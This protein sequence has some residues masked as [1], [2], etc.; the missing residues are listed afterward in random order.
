MSPA[1][2]NE[3]CHEVRRTTSKRSN[4]SAISVVLLFIL[5]GTIALSCEQNSQKSVDEKRSKWVYTVVNVRSGRSTDYPIVSQLQPG[6]KA[7]VD[8][9]DEGWYR[10]FHGEKFVGYVAEFLLKNERLWLPAPGNIWTGV[11]IYYGEDL[12]KKYIGQ[13]FGGRDRLLYIVN[14]NGDLEVYNRNYLN[15]FYYH[16]RSDDPALKKMKWRELP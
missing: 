1:D 5:I 11:N 14:E 10:V 6:E 16:V 7:K 3:C 12:N 9:L 15:P 2:Y 4:C 13:V 8:S